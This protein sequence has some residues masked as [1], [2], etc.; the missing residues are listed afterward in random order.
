MLRPA[1]KAILSEATVTGGKALGMSVQE[2]C[3]K[4]STSPSVKIRQGTVL[5]TVVL[6][7]S[8]RDRVPGYD[9]FALYSLTG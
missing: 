1:W 7:F 2:G 4:G 3:L 5:Q 8:T 9:R 6:L